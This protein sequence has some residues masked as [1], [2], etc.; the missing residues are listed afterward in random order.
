MGGK[1]VGPLTLGMLWA[2]LVLCATAH[3]ER[4]TVE[5]VVN[6][7]APYQQES[8]IYTLRV[9]SV[10]A[11]DTIDP[12]PSMVQGAALEKLDGPISSLRTTGRSPLHVT[13]FRYLLTALRPG[14][15]TIPPPT[16]SVRLAGS[17]GVGGYGAPG[18]TWQQPYGRPMPGPGYGSPMTQQPYGQP[19]GGPQSMTPPGLP[20]GGQQPFTRPYGQPGQQPLGQQPSGRQSYGP[21]PYGQQPSGRQSYGPQPYGQ[22]PSGRQS[23]GPQPYGQQPFGWQPYGQQGQQPYGPAYAQQPFGPGHTR[24]AFG[25]QPY[26]ASGY[27]P[28]ATPV[29]GAEM[30]KL[31]GPEVD[32][33]VRP[34]A[35]TDVAWRPLR[36]LDLQAQWSGQS[37]ARVGEPLTVTL[38]LTATGAGGEQLPSLSSYL[39]SDDFK[40]YPDQPTFSVAI[41][42]QGKEVTGKR[43]ESYTLIPQRGGDLE[44]PA[45]RIPWWDV[46][47]RRLNWVEW[48][49]QL[50]RVAG[51]VGSQENKSSGPSYLASALSRMS[52][53]FWIGAILAVGWWLGA[54]RPGSG[55]ALA[56]WRRVGAVV[57]PALVRLWS[58]LRSGVKA[59][60]PAN[61]RATIALTAR[62]LVPAPVRARMPALRMAFKAPRLVDNIRL[63]RRLQ[64][65]EDLSALAL[66]L[67][68]YG[69]TQLGVSPNVPLQLLGHAFAESSPRM[70]AQGI[71]QRLEELEGAI[72]G[73]RPIDVAVWKQATRVHLR[74]LGWTQS[75]RRQQRSQ[76]MRGLPSLN[77]SR[78]G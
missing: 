21:Q 46:T 66:A 61:M 14:T 23:Y 1:S 57:G 53:V 72:Y 7:R 29:S 47:Y 18:R 77:P 68:E 60:V 42:P 70:D 12:S 17:T 62:E 73:E 38:T 50:I 59:A 48:P 6:N 40:L 71:I 2:L 34:P 10:S 15:L 32:L 31:V 26:A 35:R 33:E 27:G 69:R 49:A 63:V 25:Q 28:Q 56:I 52:A 8:V 5:V 19:Y 4:P 55:R 11:V 67:H 74:H 41:D 13:E 24:Q 3:A 37:D 20:T 9:V 45:V 51:G 65:R 22:Q 36:S 16:V 76:G 39:E 30:M 43:V 58:A 78:M 75:S 54:G 64:S 44:I